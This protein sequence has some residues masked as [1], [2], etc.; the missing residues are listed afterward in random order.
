MFTCMLFVIFGAGQVKADI[1]ASGQCGDNVYYTISDSGKAVISGTG[2]IWNYEYNSEENE[3]PFF[4]YE[5][6]QS[7]IN[8]I[9]VEAGVTRIGDCLFAG[10][11][12]VTSVTLPEGLEE[13]G[14][15]SFSGTNMSEITLPQSLKF[16]E[17]YAFQGCMTLETVH[18]PSNVYYI[19]SAAY[20]FCGAVTAYTV[21]EENTYFSDL[22]G[23]LFDKSKTRIIKYPAARE[24]AYTIPDT[25]TSVY[26]YAF[27]CA[28]LT[29]ITIPDN[30]ISFAPY[31]FQNCHSLTSVY[32]PGSMGAVEFCLFCGCTSLREVTIGSGMGR[33]CARAFEGC[34]ALKFI[35]IPDTVTN[36]DYAAFAMCWQLDGIYVPSS[37]TEFGEEVFRQTTTM[38]TIYGKP[39]SKA[40]NYADANGITFKAVDGKCGEDVYW[41]LDQNGVLD[42][43]GSGP[44]Y[45]YTIPI[46]PRIPGSPFAGNADITKVNILNGVTRVG[47]LSFIGCTG[48]TGWSQPNL[49]GSL[50]EIGKNAF[51]ACTSITDLYIPEGTE[52]IEDNAFSGCTALE[53]AYFAGTQENPMVFGTNIYDK[54]DNFA[55]YARLDTTAVQDAIAR[56]IKVYLIDS[57]EYIDL[58]IP[59]QVTVIEE[60]AF[61]G[62]AAT[63]ISM[64][65]GVTAINSRAFADSPNLEKIFIPDTCTSIASDAFEGCPS[66]LMIYCHED[67]CAETFAREHGYYVAVAP[68]G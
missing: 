40:Q 68:R 66:G 37:Y 64:G 59:Y 19:G 18:I 29:D 27:D 8:E 34:S 9:E 22:D 47:D 14:R 4:E 31:A 62:T 1:V 35:E 16:I 56:G 51:R 21:D 45:D 61:S 25:V 5:Y 65:E 33:I 3:S 12:S 30:G 55:V 42:I 10:C 49:P 52:R 60:E 44:M 57:F 13:I 28:L 15:S 48:I 6:Y 67:T 39:S 36:I 23:V 43:F 11:N 7:E 20:S 24:G 41:S 54:T 46:P 58:D 2:D 38:L 26:Y 53:Y 17:D 50:K 63:H 32:L